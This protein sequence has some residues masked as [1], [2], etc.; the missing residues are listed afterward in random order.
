MKNHSP[1]VSLC[2]AMVAALVSLPFIL[3][4]VQCCFSDPV[5]AAPP[6]SNVVPAKAN[7]LVFTTPAGRIMTIIEAGDVPE[8]VRQ[9]AA[10]GD[11]CRTLG[12]YFDSV[13]DGDTT[14]TVCRS[15]KTTGPTIQIV[16]N[17][18]G[19]FK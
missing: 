18:M 16:T 9:L 15:C 19:F 12:H 14:R 4:I 11:L 8:L 1:L 3:L 13:R 10:K 7:N 17:L 5:V 6:P 2:C